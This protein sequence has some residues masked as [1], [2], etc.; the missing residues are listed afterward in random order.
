MVLQNFILNSAHFFVNLT[1]FLAVCITI[2]LLI[3]PT[4]DFSQLNSTT[5]VESLEIWKLLIA[6]AVLA[7]CMSPLIRLAFSKFELILA[8]AS[9]GGWLRYLYVATPSHGNQLLD[10]SQ[11]IGIVL[12][13]SVYA[14]VVVSI[15]GL[16]LDQ[17]ALESLRNNLK[18]R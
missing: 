17:K 15:I 4:R 7:A 6:A 16:G 13:F 11:N 2:Y 8:L 10:F 5:I 9:I 12:Y 14:V 18:R 3:S 1:A